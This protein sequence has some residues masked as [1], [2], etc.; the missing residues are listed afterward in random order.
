MGGYVESPSFSVWPVAIP[1]TDVVLPWG[2]TEQAELP[3]IIRTS[4]S[5]GSQIALAFL[6]HEALK[7]H[8][9]RSHGLSVGVDYSPFDNAAPNQLEIYL[10]QSFAGAYHQQ[11]SLRHA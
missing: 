9:N 1:S 10:A 2:N 8:S 3:S 6:C 11:G 5:H 4:A 7:H